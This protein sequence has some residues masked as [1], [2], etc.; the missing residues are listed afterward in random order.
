M[1]K[2]N[3][4]VL[5]NCYSLKNEASKGISFTILTLE[6]ELL[7]TVIG[8]FITESVNN[9]QDSIYFKTPFISVVGSLETSKILDLKS[10]AMKSIT[11]ELT[12]NDLIYFVISFI[13]ASPISYRNSS[14][15]F[16][17]TLTFL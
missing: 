12:V 16:T 2:I 15:E 5:S 1:S 11:S 7:Y 17:S 9:L 3:I 8:N 6:S 13:K 10:K 14:G 4:D